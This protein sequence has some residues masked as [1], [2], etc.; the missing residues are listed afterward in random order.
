MKING[1]IAAGRVCSEMIIIKMTRFIP[2]SM[3]VFIMHRAFVNIFIIFYYAYTYIYTIQ[4]CI[5]L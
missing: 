5:L 3:Y 4:I 1:V 2:F